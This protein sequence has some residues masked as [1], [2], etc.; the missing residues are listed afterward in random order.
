MGQT[1]QRALHASDK[2]RHHRSSTLIQPRSRSSRNI[3]IYYKGE[4]KEIPIE[5]SSLTCGWLLSE[6]IRLFPDVFPIVGLRSLLR[7]DVIDVWLHEF[8]RSISIIRD[9]TVLSPIIGQQI[10]KNICLAW[11]EPLCVIGKGGF[12]MVY[13]VRKRDNGYLY[14]MKVMQKSHILK[15]N[16]VKHVASECSIMKKIQH[17]FIISL[18]WAFQTVNFI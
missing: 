7:A 12:S 6:A 13:L 9:A 14:A 18:H 16:K 11:F 2:D 10:P 4:T 5:D 8:E 1:N 3:K 15:E 17:P